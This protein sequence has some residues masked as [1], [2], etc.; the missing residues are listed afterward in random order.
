[1]TV[2]ELI[3]HLQR[4]DAELEAVV[5]DPADGIPLALASVW[6]SEGSPDD[7]EPQAVE[8]TLAD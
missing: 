7:D 5:V 1:M 8:L 3:R 6:L 4:F 2:G